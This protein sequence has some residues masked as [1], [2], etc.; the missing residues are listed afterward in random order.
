MI[1]FEFK[2]SHLCNFYWTLLKGKFSEQELEATHYE[3]HSLYSTRFLVKDIH[4][5]YYISQLLKAVLTF[6]ERNIK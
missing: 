5:P 6:N 2:D 1:T 3:F 4:S